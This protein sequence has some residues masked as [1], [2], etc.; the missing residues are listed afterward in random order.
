[1][2]KIPLRLCVLIAAAVLLA[3]V[4]AW[5]L[6]WPRGGQAAAREGPA[7]ARI[8]KH[9]RERNVPALGREVAHRD[10]AVARQAVAAL[11]RIG[12]ESLPEVR[13]ALRDSRGPVRERAATVFA[14]IAPR[15]DATALAQVAREDASSDVR[16]AAVSGLNHMCA[17]EQMEAILAAMDDSDEVVRRRAATAARRFAC[18]RV[19]F[20]ADDPPQ[21][22]KA[23]IQRMRSVWLQHE[24]RARR[25]WEMILKK[26][27][28]KPP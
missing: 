9:R 8:D 6:F 24:A 2:R 19:G 23:A 14:R 5:Q 1:M 28:P 3:A 13:R 17:F 18:A 20:K 4:A 26:N 22:R 27:R 12:P 21:K 15:E 11:G 16:A 7:A 25:Y 10:V